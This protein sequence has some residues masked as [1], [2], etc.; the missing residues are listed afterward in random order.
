DVGAELA[1][2]KRSRVPLLHRLEA[3][4]A[5]G[6]LVPGPGHVLGEPAE[7]RVV[8]QEV[9]QRLVVGQ[10]VDAHQLDVG[11][12]G[13]RGAVEVASDPAEPVD[14]YSYGHRRSLRR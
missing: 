12:A 13:Q 6:D 1:P 11:A 14:P 8:L 9:R 2:G 10:V 5:D 4:T 3:V 7:D